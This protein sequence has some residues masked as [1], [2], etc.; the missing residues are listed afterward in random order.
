MLAGF[1]GIQSNSVSVDTVGD[2]LANAN[3]TAFKS[4]RTLFETLL[5]RTIHEGTAPTGDTGGT[6]PEQIGSGSGVATIQR[7]FA[8]GSVESTGF[9]SDLAVDGNGFFILTAPTGEQMY[10]RDGSF[11]LD[12]TGTVVSAS[13]RPLQVYQ[14]DEAGNETAVSSKEA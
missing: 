13:G 10:T 6:L 2:N 8:Q 14:A 7:N 4:Q 12:E 3:T 9:A 1:T 5:Y 11:R